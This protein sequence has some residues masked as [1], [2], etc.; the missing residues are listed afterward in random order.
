MITVEGGFAKVVN[1]E[2]EVEDKFVMS[3]RRRLWND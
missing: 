2:T 3:Y 1:V